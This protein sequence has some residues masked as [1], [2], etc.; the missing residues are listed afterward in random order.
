MKK[1]NIKPIMVII[2]LIGLGLVIGG[3]LAYFSTT[4]TF[5]NEFNASDYVIEVKET[6]ESPDNWIPGDTTQKEIIATNK[7][8]TTA[9]VRVKLT[10]SWKD[11]NGDPLDLTDNNDNEAAIIN[12]SFDLDYKWIKDGDWYYYIRPIDKNESTSSIIESVTFNPLINVS[13]T[14]CE[15][16]AETGSLVCTSGSTGYGGGTYTLNVDIETCQYDKYKEIWNTN[17]SIEASEKKDGT[18]KRVTVDSYDIYG[19]PGNISRNAFESVMVLDII[20]IPNNAIES[21]D[22]SEEQ[23]ESIMCWYTDIDND[24]KYELYIGQEG[25]VK[26]NPNSE[27]AFGNYHYAT[28]LNMKY[29]DTSEVTDMNHMFFYSGYQSSN[30]GKFQIKGLDNWDTSEV[31]DMSFMFSFAGRYNPEYSIGDLS[32]WNTSN[33]KY[34]NNMFERTSESAFKFDIGNIGNWNV[35]NVTNM[36]SMFEQAGNYSKYWSIGD[37]S[38]W[39]TSNVSTMENMFFYAGYGAISWNSIGTLKIYTTVI[40]DIMFSV[41]GAKA[42]FN[43]YSNPTGYGSAFSYAATKEGSGITVNYSSNTTNI[44]NI[45][46]TKSSN[47]NVVKGSLLD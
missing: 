2:L 45:I 20:N 31:E 27:N 33:V 13:D 39:N 4:D 16:E 12:Y 3:T 47:S 6:F 21:W 36:K 25:G 11:A 10:P 43:I 38:N 28:Y 18:L 7:S 29:L 32:K 34:M 35:S 22:C 37:L 44:D 41:G 42:T 30:L 46:A 17:V 8:D 40:S 1:F 15:T 19:N 14:S 5:N 23:N 26:A 24:S 9:A